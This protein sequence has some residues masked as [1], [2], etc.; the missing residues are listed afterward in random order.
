MKN[1]KISEKAHAKIVANYT[2]GENFADVLDRLLGIT[3]DS[4]STTTTNVKKGVRK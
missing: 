3:A 4:T 2:F 1:I